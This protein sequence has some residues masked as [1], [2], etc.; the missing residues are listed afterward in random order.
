MKTKKVSKREIESM[1]MQV[2]IKNALESLGIKQFV[3]SYQDKNGVTY[4]TNCKD[5]LSMLG[6]IWVLNRQADDTLRQAKI[7]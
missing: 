4:A 5:N 6:M 7:D 2:K 3:A 1:D